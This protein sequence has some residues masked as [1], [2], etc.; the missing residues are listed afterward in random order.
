[1][2]MPTTAPMPISDSASDSPPAPRPP[3]VASASAK[4]T[5]GVAIPSFRPLSTFRTRLMRVA[6]PDWSRPAGQGRR[7]LERAPRRSSRARPIEI[8]GKSNTALSV[9][10]AIVSSRPTISSRP[11]VTPSR[12][13]GASW[14]ADASAKRS[15]VSVVSA[16]ILIGSWPGSSGTG[17][18]KSSDTTRPIRTNASAVRPR[19]GRDALPPAHIRRL[20]ARAMQVRRSSAEM[21][22][23]ADARQSPTLSERHTHIG[24]DGAG[25]AAYPEVTPESA[26]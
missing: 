23:G 16:R 24:R 5:N 10:R 14:M 13:Q 26:D 1:M 25:S 6:L 17:P 11:I 4:K 20:A 7:P 8:D 12:L 21:S 9:P 2:P 15:K 18:S 3:S 19:N 22:T